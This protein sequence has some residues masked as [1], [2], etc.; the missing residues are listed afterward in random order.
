MRDLPLQIVD[1][2][3]IALRERVLQFNQHL[4]RCFAVHNAAGDIYVH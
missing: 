4:S 3:T 2:G 1:L